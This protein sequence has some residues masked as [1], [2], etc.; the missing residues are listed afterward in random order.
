[1]FNIKYLTLC[2]TA[3]CL[4]G[5]VAQAKEMGVID[6]G[7]GTLI[8]NEGD[9]IKNSAASS[10]TAISAGKNDAYSVSG[11]GGI[12][13][14]VST[15]EGYL[16][17]I[18]AVGGGRVDLGSGTRMFLNNS[19]QNLTYGMLRRARPQGLILPATVQ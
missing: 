19:G 15:S 10:V 17:G 16:T 3:V 2:I 11:S 6:K 9:V 4:T 7:K 1:M 12:T 5:H 14:D 18:F 13:V 8:L